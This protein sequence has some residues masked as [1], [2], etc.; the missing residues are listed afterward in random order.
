MMARPERRG[1]AHAPA[2]WRRRGGW[3]WVW[4]PLA[5]VFSALVGVRRFLYR[6]GML[7]S[8]HPGVPVVIVGNI[9]VGGSGKT[10]VVIAL[11]AALRAAGWR[12]GIVSRGYG[13]SAVEARA[14]GADDDPAE[15]GDEP[16]LLARETGC[17]VVVAADRVAAARRLRAIDPAC[18]VIVAD[19]GLQHYRLARDVEVIVVDEAVLGNA[20][21]LPA[22]PLREGMGRLQ[23]ADL[24]IVQGA[25]SSSLTARLQ[26]VPLV[27]MTLQGTRLR[28]LTT[29][30]SRELSVFAGRRV[31]ALAG[32]G[33]PQRFFDQLRAAGLEVVEHAFAD[34]H[35]FSSEDLAAA[36][37]A[38][39][40][41]TSKD[42][43]KCLSFA[44][45]DT[46][47]FPVQAVVAPAAWH[48][49]VEKL[50][51]GRSSA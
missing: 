12:P 6:Q 28:E 31:H 11:C 41:M 17:A 4:L 42:A 35:A 43:V 2:F 38:P 18:D 30:E 15:C 46:W 49:I 26:Q 19:D 13:G 9:A 20:W 39:R 45:P 25:P 33:R 34:H 51:H 14:V 23:H 44:P 32:I 36:A 24:V 1:G 7:R 48:I 22:G 21:P 10:P 37:D 8:E 47:E 40:V 29:G 16:V 50:R 3:A 5:L 27:S